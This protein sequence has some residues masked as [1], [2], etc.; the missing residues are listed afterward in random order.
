[1]GGR[2]ENSLRTVCSNSEVLYTNTGWSM[3]SSLGQAHIH[4]TGVICTNIESRDES[5]VCWGSNK[6]CGAVYYK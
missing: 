2:Q 6:D 1:M 3:C 5:A 4:E